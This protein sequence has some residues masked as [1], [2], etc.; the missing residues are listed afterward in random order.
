MHSSYWS[1]QAFFIMAGC[2]NTS[3]HFKLRRS[4]LGPPPCPRTPS[5]SPAK[6]ADSTRRQLQGRGGATTLVILMLIEDAFAFYK[7]NKV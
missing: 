3:Y 5:C 2:Y 7:E 4:Y 6:P 1:V